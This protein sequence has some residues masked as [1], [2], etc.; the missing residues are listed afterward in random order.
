MEKTL[1]SYQGSLPL[2]PSGSIWMMFITW[3]SYSKVKEY[4]PDVLNAAFNTGTS[5]YLR[6]SVKWAADIYSRRKIY[7]SLTDVFISI[8]IQALD[9]TQIAHLHHKVFDHN[10]NSLSFLY[11]HIPSLKAYA[12]LFSSAWSSQQDFAF[13]VYSLGYNIF[14]FLFCQSCNRRICLFGGRWVLPNTSL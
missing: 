2:F 8:K 12:L 7:T 6:I 13:N 3:Q 5:I 10:K 4:F 14:S 1:L 9:R 11:T